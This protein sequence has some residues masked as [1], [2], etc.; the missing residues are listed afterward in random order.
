LTLFPSCSVPLQSSALRLHLS[1]LLESNEDWIEAAKVLQGIPLGSGHRSVPNIYKLR[2]YV[3]IVRLLLEGDDSIGADTFLKRASL[4]IHSVPGAASR[5]GPENAEEEDRSSRM[6]EEDKI[7]ARTLGLQY[8]LCQARIYD[9][10]I[11]FAEAAIRFHEVS[12]VTDIDEGERNL[13]L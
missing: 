12:Y 6:S 3:R 8:K 2:I 7:E 11:R 1:D 5:A 13:M 9:A 4:V 10:Q